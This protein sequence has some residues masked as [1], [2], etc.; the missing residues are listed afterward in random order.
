MASAEQKISLIMNG[1]EE[2]LEHVIKAQNFSLKDFLSFM[3]PKFV[4]AG[5]RDTRKFNRRVNASRGGYGIL[6][7]TDVAAG[8]FLASTSAIR[9]IR[10]LYPDERITLVVH[11]RSFNLAEY[12]PYVDEIILNPQYYSLGDKFIEFY[13]ANM[14]IA[15]QLLERH[16]DIGFVFSVHG[17][18]E[19]LMYMSGARIRVTKIENQ[20]AFNGIYNMKYLL[21][22]LS[23][24]IFPNDAFGFHRVDTNLSLLENM[25]HLPISNR[26]MEVWCSPF[27]IS[28][29]KEYLK[30]ASGSIYSLNMGGSTPHNHYPPEKYVRLLELILREEPTATFV[31]LGAGKEDLKSAEII[32]DVVPKIYE[33]NIIDLTDKITYRQSGAVLSFC[34]MH[35]GNDTGTLHI[36]SAVDC[37]ILEPICFAADLKMLNTDCPRR[38][39]PYG[40]PS[41][42]VQPEHILAECKL[43]NSHAYRGCRANIPHCIVQIEPQT[44]FKGFQL[45]K[46]RIAKKINEPIYIH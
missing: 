28:I 23:T 9:E 24:H 35:I 11:P 41:V 44:L 16:F 13:K 10:R 38:W 15:R 18:S 37:P 1:F 36:A 12:C 4:K 14:I 26:Q 46:E 39:Y 7:L 25:L 20:T 5:Y 8:D 42:V 6:L 33:R 30:N 2:F 22:R 21:K 17:Y 40:V 32:K 34:K 43:P 29:A 31:I 19:L 3:E 27:D 45:L